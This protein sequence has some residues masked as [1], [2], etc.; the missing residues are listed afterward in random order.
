MKRRE[1]RE[2]DEAAAREQAERRTEALHARLRAHEAASRHRT[3]EDA[4]AAVPEP[5]DLQAPE[6]EDEPS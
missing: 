5:E 3:D 1:V 2:R 6:T 4:T